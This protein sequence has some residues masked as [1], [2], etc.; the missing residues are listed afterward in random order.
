MA[1]YALVIPLNVSSYSIGDLID[2]VA[3]NTTAVNCN[4]ISIAQNYFCQPPYDV[5]AFYAS[6][7]NVNGCP[8][9]LFPR[10]NLSQGSIGNAANTFIV[11]LDTL[12]NAVDTVYIENR[13]DFYNNLQYT[14]NDPVM[15]AIMMA[16]F[17]GILAIT[18]VIKII[19]RGAQ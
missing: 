19:K 7:R 17:T 2:D 4:T 8:S 14:I 12:S 10:L 18:S 3:K 5:E 13:Q 11:D 6:I 9:E 1:N 16:V 15:W